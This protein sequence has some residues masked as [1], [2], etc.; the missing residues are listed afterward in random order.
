MIIYAVWAKD[1]LLV[2]RRTGEDGRL[3]VREQR[4]GRVDGAPPQ[5]EAVRH[6]VGVLRAARK[7]G[8]EH[9][10]YHI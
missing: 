7:F 5:P 3:E 2:Q 8:L 6:A 9:Y 1:P 4:N 10:A